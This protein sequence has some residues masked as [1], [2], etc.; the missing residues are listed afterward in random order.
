MEDVDTFY[1]HLVYF[2]V[3]FTL[4]LNVLRTGL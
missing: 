2:T 3:Y 4:Q 1:D